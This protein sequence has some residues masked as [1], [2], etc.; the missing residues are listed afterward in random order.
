[1]SKYMEGKEMFRDSQHGFIKLCLT[2]LMAYD[3][4]TA[5]MD[6]RQVMDFIYLEFSKTFDMVP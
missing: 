4:E 3:G 2:N 6:K 1:M 5:S